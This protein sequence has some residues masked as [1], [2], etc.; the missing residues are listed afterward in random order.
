MTTNTTVTTAKRIKIELGSL[1]FDG[2]MIEGQVDKDGLPIF[3]FSMT[4]CAMLIGLTEDA[5]QANKL[6]IQKTT[7]KEAQT[8]FPEGFEAHLN[9]KVKEL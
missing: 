4:E 3:G 8:R 6:Y 5:K 7:S 9:L 2:Y 1:T